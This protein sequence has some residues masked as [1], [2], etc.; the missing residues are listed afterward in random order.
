MATLRGYTVELPP[1]LMLPETC[2]GFTGG[3][4][5]W[6]AAVPTSVR[7]R[8]VAIPMAGSVLLK[9]VFVFIRVSSKK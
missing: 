1:V 7:L 9:A 2:A 4:F 5:V 6:P 3:S 8:A